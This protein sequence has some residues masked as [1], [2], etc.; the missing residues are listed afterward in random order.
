VISE[1]QEMI[2]AMERPSRPGEDLTLIEVTA[3]ASSSA[4]IGGKMNERE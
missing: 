4:V 2:K 3:D 1:K